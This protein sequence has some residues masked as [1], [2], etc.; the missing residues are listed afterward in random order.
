MLLGYFQDL[1]LDLVTAQSY[2]GQL[3]SVFVLLKGFDFISFILVSCFLFLCSVFLVPCVSSVSVKSVFLWISLV[4]R[5]T[6]I[7]LCPVFS[8][9]SF[10][11]PVLLCLI[12]P[13]CISTCCPSSR[14]PACVFQSSV[15]RLL[16]CCTMPFAVRVS[17][18]FRFPLL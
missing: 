2:L 4:F 9:L 13:S 5:F 14:H 15:F 10:A 17:L 8:V 3:P 1:L 12:S 11:F 18:C 16:P 6:L 7:V